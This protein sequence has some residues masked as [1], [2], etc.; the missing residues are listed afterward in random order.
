[1]MELGIKETYRPVRQLLIESHFI[2]LYSLSMI[3]R[4]A[5]VGLCLG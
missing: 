5:T 2:I 1:M 4:E 3:V